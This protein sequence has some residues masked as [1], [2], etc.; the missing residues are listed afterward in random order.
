[1]LVLTIKLAATFAFLCGCFP[2]SCSNLLSHSGDR[3][4]SIGHSDE[5]GTS[6]RPRSSTGFRPF[7]R[8][9]ERASRLSSS[10][11]ERERD[12]GRTRRVSIAHAP[13]VRWFVGSSKSR[14]LVLF[15]LCKRQELLSRFS[16]SFMFL[17]FFLSS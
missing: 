6:L 8:S 10:G 3:T 9:A 12:A 5:E 16:C 13:F 15:R 14:F 1:M 4:S 2:P 7:V 17:S 11:R